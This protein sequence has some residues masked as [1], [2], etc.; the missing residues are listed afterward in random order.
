MLRIVCEC[1]HCF[2]SMWV[3]VCMRG[4]QRVQERAH[5]AII[6]QTDDGG[7]LTESDPSIIYC[8]QLLCFLG[9][10]L[11]CMNT[12]FININTVIILHK[13]TCES[14]SQPKRENKF[15]LYKL[16]CLLWQG[17]T[18]E[19]EYIYSKIYTIWSKVYGYIII[20]PIHNVIVKRPFGCMSI[21]LLL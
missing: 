14:Q 15:I 1:S 20:P 18:D 8:L 13:H 5:V 19:R 7:R 10:S 2:I 21:N 3:L 16:Y 4:R 11:D 9:C 6:Q 12:H 17:V